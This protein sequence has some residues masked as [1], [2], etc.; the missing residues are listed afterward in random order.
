MLATPGSLPVGPEWLYEVKWD[1]WRLL[2]DVTDGRLRL[3]TRTERDVTSHFPELAPLTEMVV[4]GALDGEVV[5]LAGGVPAFSALADRIH[6]ASPG[7]APATF[8]AFDV[9][10]LYGV[11]LLDRPLAER[12]ATLERLELDK[13]PSVQ[14]S[15][16][17]TDGPALLDA[18]R[19]QGLEGVLAKRRDSIYRPGRRS[20]AW[21][22]VAHRRTQACVIGGWR[23]EKTNPRIGSLLLGVYDDQGKLRFAGRTGAGPGGEA[24]QRVLRKELTPLARPDSPFDEPLPRPE[25]VGVNWCEPRL[26]VDVNHVGWTEDHRLR[27]PILRGVRADL[28]PSEVHRE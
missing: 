10:R 26:V 17:Y 5:V 18:T 28:D 24:T 13:A 25:R 27:H 19:E 2:A 8:I 21:V 11:P 9:L 14:L 12:R 22:K 7:S 16:I 6:A 23:E 15:P 4:D 3:T 1:G 20:P